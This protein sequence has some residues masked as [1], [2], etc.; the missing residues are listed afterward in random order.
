MYSG[1]V[2]GKLDQ[3]F[4]QFE[5]HSTMGRDIRPGQLEELLGA[6]RDWSNRTKEVLTTIDVTI[7]HADVHA[8][9]KAENQK[10]WERARQATVTE[11]V[12]VKMGPTKGRD[13]RDEEPMDVDVTGAHTRRKPTSGGVEGGLN[14]A[15]NARKR[16]RGG[17]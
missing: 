9:Q 8:A 10:E 6:L 7:S 5:V 14:A 17:P 12:Q 2:S 13:R 15:T 11:L 3:K 4:S 1:I 16:H